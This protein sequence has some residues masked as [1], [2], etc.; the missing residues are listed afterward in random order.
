MD[1]PNDARNFLKM[2]SELRDF[3]EEWGYQM[4]T[5]RLECQ[6][7][8]DYYSYHLLD[9]RGAGMIITIVEPKIIKIIA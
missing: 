2:Y 8:Y 3:S 4:K 1:A 5:T 7:Y 6:R 9:K